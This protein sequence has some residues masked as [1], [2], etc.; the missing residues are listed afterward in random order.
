MV[1]KQGLASQV[2]STETLALNGAGGERLDMTYGKTMEVLS[3]FCGL[4][5]QMLFS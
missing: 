5:R 4:L 2:D 3:R 1:M